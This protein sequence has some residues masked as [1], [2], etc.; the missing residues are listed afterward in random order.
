MK[1]IEINLSNGRLYK[2]KKL[3]EFKM[4]FLVN[5]VMCTLVKLFLNYKN[6]GENYGKI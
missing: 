4:Y 6:E 3:N 2:F 5:L 1:A